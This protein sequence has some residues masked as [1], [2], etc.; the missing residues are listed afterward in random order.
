MISE[1]LGVDIPFKFKT[2]RINIMHDAIVPGELFI[3]IQGN[4]TEKKR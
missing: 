1:I 3:S 4:T 2:T